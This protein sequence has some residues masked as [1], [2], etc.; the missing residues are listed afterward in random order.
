MEHSTLNNIITLLALSVFAVVLMR[1]INLPAILGYLFIGALAGTHGLGFIPDLHAVHLIAEIGVVFLL[2]MIGLEFSIPQMMSMKGIVL[3]LGGVQVTLTTTIAFAISM[4]FGMDWQ[5]AF[6]VGGVI[7]LSSTAIAAKQLGEQLELQS[8]HGRIAIGILIFQDIAVVPFL[9]LIPIFGMGGDASLTEPLLWAL[10]KG[11]FAFALMFAVGHWLLRP[12][13]HHVAGAQSVELFT[14]TILLV[15]L[16]AAWLTDAMGLSLALGAFLAGMMLGETEYRHQIEIEIRPFRDVL[17]GLFFISVGAQVHLDQVPGILHWVL[18]TT[19]GLVVGKGLLVALVV[20][21][22][23]RE[24]GIALRSGAVLAQGGEFGFALMTL[25]I[26]NNL[27]EEQASQIILTSVVLSM[28]LAPLIIRNNGLLAKTI[29]SRSYM[30]GREQQTQM[31]E[32][33]SHEKQGHVVICG[34]GRIGQNLAGFLVEEGFEYVA[35][36]VDPLL[37]REA[38]DAGEDVFYGDSTHSEILEVAGVKRARALVITVDEDH[39]SARIT[40]AARALNEDIAIVVRTR[41]DAHREELKAAGATDVVPEAL[42]ASMMLASRLLQRLDVP[43]EEVMMLVEQ[44]RQNQ[45]ARLR[46]V[47]HGEN[48]VEDAAELDRDRLHTV[49]LEEGA[50][51][52]GHTVGEIKEKFVDVVVHSLRRGSIVGDL[53]EDSMILVEGDAVVLRGAVDDLEHAEAVLLGG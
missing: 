53:P 6:V 46:G 47:F 15:A 4:W 41:N 17:M 5:G 25:A 37:I 14:L 1:R 31:I 44:A 43:M 13:F 22:S 38:H 27:L 39:I 21:L 49:L 26:S 30:G 42:E 11:I 10:G 2:F 9:V 52:V 20:R 19:L 40:R 34:F 36:D 24:Q 32:A 33:S 3:G 29:C 35:L 28:V 51:G 16:S 45:Y 7:A 48:E 50:F 8:R 12:L 18:L 23:G